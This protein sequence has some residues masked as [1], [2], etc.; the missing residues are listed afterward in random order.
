MC[1]V[2]TTLRIHM[3]GIHFL[4][5][6]ALGSAAA[7]LPFFIAFAFIAL[8]ILLRTGNWANGEVTLVVHDKLRA[9]CMR[10]KFKHC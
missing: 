3:V 5:F 7:F 10:F 2:A 4:A 1:A 6:I 9:N 8:G